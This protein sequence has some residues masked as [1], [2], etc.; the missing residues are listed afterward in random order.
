MKHYADIIIYDKD[1]SKPSNRHH[2]EF[3]DIS[4]SEF[5]YEKHMGKLF[6]LPEGELT[7]ETQVYSWQWCE[8]E[9]E[10]EE[11]QLIENGDMISLTMAGGA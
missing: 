11:Q 1:K 7:N 3:P 8:A 4:V 10:A 5:N 6:I 9:N 2:F